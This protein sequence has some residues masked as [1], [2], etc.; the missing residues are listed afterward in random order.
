[1]KILVLQ[2]LLGNGKHVLVEKPLWAPDE[3]SIRQLEVTA[4]KNGAICYVAYNH[5]FEPHFARMRETI[6]AGTL[7]ALYHCRMFYG[8]GTARLVRESEWRGKGGGG[9]PGL[10]S[11]PP[12][13]AAICFRG[14]RPGCCIPL[15]R[16][17]SK[18]PAPP[19]PF[20]PSP[21]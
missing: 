10:G 1:P 17:L 12:P 8:N 5:R 18:P 19:V 21:T 20:P 13:T 15:T 14:I 11:H 7:G 9:F 2:Y 4:R 6:V 3:D 16:P